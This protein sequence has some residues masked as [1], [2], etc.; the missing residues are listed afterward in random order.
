MKNQ[1]Q[2]QLYIV[3]NPKSF[4][5]FEDHRA[6]LYIQLHELVEKAIEDKED[7]IALIENYLQLEYN[8]GNTPEDIANFLF[9]T[10]TMTHAMHTLKDNWDTFDN[11]LPEDTLIYG[12]TTREQ[13]I[14][15]YYETTL[16]SYLEALAV[17]Y[18]TLDG[19]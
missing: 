19:S 8:A 4:E 16:R 3:S 5:H 13:A 10:D 18:Q 6:A 1:L 12:K 11:T 7:P 9:H 2:L 17:S 15:T 14:N